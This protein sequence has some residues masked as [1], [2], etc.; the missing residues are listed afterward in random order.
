MYLVKSCSRGLLER[1][2]GGDHIVLVGGCLPLQLAA[3]ITI[4]L[5]LKQ[6]QH[7]WKASLPNENY[8]REEEAAAVPAG[9]TA[10]WAASAGAT[11]KNI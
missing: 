3:S 5:E 4:K 10:C 7:N 11:F 6:E 1:R 2:Q 8:A 9:C